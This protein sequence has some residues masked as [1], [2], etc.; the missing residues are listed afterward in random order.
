MYPYLFP[1]ILGNLVPLYDVLVVIGIFMMLWYVMKRLEQ[2]DG[3]TRAQTNRILLLL[4]ISIFVALPIAMVFDGLF[5]SLAEREF[6]FGSITFLGGL[7]GG[8]TAF[9]I[10][11]KFFYKYENKHMKKILNTVITGVV[12]A[13]VFGRIG[14]FFAGCCYGVPT[15]SMFAVIFPHGLAHETFPDTGIFP[16]QLFEAF[17]LFLLFIILN[18]VKYFKNK[19]AITYLIAYGTWRFLLEFIRGDERGVLFPLY[20]TQ[21]NIFPTPS[22]FLSIIMVILGMILIVK[23]KRKPKME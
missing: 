14:C 13:H 7:I 19:E 8:I 16:T 1:D 12:L 3:H 11:M 9:I 4:I 17:F 22:Q 5:H 23:A 20:E 10:L 2:K 15:E 6:V 21:Y 18:N